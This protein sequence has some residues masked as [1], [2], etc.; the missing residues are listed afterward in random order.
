[1]FGNS[2]IRI[3]L[4]SLTIRVILQNSISILVVDLLINCKSNIDSFSQW[5]CAVFLTQQNIPNCTH[6][7]CY[8]SII[9]HFM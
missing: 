1:M 7:L 2:G 8:K 4:I 5:F 9:E 3:F 6:L